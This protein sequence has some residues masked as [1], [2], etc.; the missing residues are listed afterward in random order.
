MITEEDCIAALQKASEILGHSPS[1]PEYSDLD[2]SPHHDT[3]RRKCGSWNKAKKKANLNTVGPGGTKD[4]NKSYFD[5]IDTSEKAYWLGFLYGDGSVVK[6]TENSNGVQ[7]AVQESDREVIENYKD[8]LESEHTITESNGA[9]SLNFW[10]DSLVSDLKRHGLTR[11]KTRSDSTPNLTN[12]I[13]QAA[14]IRGLFDA[15]GHWGEFSRFNI[16]GSNKS[17]FEKLGNWLPV[18]YYITDRGDGV[19][20]FRVGGEARI[21]ELKNWLYPQGE[22]TKPALSRKIPT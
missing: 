2:I 21:N 11:N 4:I 22:N 18:E 20:T 6:N 5:E 13:L 16:T 10:T 3:I 9:V 14:F 19:Y 8:A 7:L 15:D 17:R 12:N 1:R